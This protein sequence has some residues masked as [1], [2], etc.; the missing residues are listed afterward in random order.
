M[1]K[2][3]EIIGLDCGADAASG[4]KL[5]LSTR[6]EEMCELRAAALEWSD[7]EGVHDMRVASRRLRSAMRDFA[8][9][10]RRGM[11]RLAPMRN[12]LKKIAD[13]LGAVRDQDV[14]IMAL[15]KLAVEDAPAEIAAN[16]LLL[17]QERRDLRETARARLRE[18]IREEALARLQVEFAGALD[19]ALRSKRGGR[20]SA[21]D[22][23]T[24]MS[25]SFRE[26]GRDITRSRFEELQK[27][28]KSLY[29][30]F[31]PGPLHRMRIAAKR[32]RYALELFAPCW[33]AFDASLAEEVAEMQTSLGEL[34]DCDIWIE[35]LGA[36]LLVEDQRTK[37]GDAVSAQVQQRRAIAWL[38]GHFVK[39]RSRHFRDALTRS[40]KWEESGFATQLNAAVTAQPTPIILRP[41]SLTAAGAVAADREAQTAASTN[42]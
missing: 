2:A 35:S 10:L 12:D 22:K 42:A 23:K 15:E 19:H 39:W 36:R 13:V 9:L 8:P 7:V 21:K 30:P 34:H 18:A 5:V 20:K 31:T 40:I 16:I 3:K 38:L 28:S 14:A 4:I 37:I 1:T 33:E 26:A 17:A 27:L 11:R 32:L 25:M 6:L 29:R 24:A 41:M